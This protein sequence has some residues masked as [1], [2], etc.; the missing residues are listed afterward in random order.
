MNVSNEFQLIG[1]NGETIARGT[2]DQILSFIKHL[3]PDG[4]Y[5]IVGNDLNLHCL[6]KDG[7]IEP[8]PDGVLF[9]SQMK[10]YEDM[11][12]AERLVTTAKGMT[13]C[14]GMLHELEARQLVDGADGQRLTPKGIAGFDQLKAEGWTPPEDLAMAVLEDS[15]GDNAE[16]IWQLIQ[17]ILEEDA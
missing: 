8:D 11:T 14:L 6:C 3:A 1:S 4:R 9:G 10:D 15:C 2:R 13:W 16:V 12:E 17:K 5:R 7:I